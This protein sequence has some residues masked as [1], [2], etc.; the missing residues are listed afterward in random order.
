MIT[1]YS[2]TFLYYQMYKILFVTQSLLSFYFL[3]LKMLHPMKS[4][5]CWF[6]Q[7]YQREILQIGG[8]F[9]G[10]GRIW[11][12]GST[13]FVGIYEFQCTLHIFNPTN[14]SVEWWNLEKWLHPLPRQQCCRINFMLV[15]YVMDILQKYSFGSKQ[16]S[17]LQMRMQVQECF[18]A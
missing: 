4:S 7:L 3:F 5:G 18:T 12:L 6:F 13:Y 1:Y 14:H 9:F 8:V 10:S 2:D 11:K 15:W 17:V 16:M